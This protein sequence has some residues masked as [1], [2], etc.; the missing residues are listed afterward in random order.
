M[1]VF[2]VVLAIREIVTAVFIVVIVGEVE[3]AVEGEKVG[4]NRL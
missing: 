2:S 1:L 3:E 4:D